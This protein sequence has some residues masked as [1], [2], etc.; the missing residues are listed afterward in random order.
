VNTRGRWAG[1]IGDAG[2]AAAFLAA[3]AVAAIAIAGS[4]GGLYWAF[5]CA[6]G[7]IVSVIA[8]LRRRDRVGAAIAGLAV[9]ALAI[10]VATLAHLPAEPGAMVLALSVLV[11]SAIRTLPP[12]PSGAIAAAGLAVAAG[13]RL[14]ALPSGHSYG[15]SS[16]ATVLNGAG[17]VAAVTVGLALRLIDARRSATIESVRR[18]ERLELARELHDVAAHHITGIVL[19]SQAARIVARRHPEQ[20]DA[21]LTDIE[22]AGSDALAAMRR[23]VGLLRDTEDAAPAAAGPEDLRELVRR[24]E[25]QDSDGQ[26]RTVRLLLPDDSGAPWPPEVT[27]TVYRVVQESLTNIAQHAQQASAV[28]VSVTRDSQAV[29]VEVVDDA[30]AAPATFHHRDGY[31]LIGMRERVEALGGTVTAGPGRSGGWS[32]LATLPA[33]T[34]PAGTGE[35]P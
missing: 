24:F 21:S 4:W 35:R 5:D 12:V 14:A 31:G 13:T 25:E 7:A 19:Q 1:A 26:R 29:T 28:T 2:L 3:I 8:L 23:V 11:G 22:S 17:W 32:V 10:P 34:L 15:H 16:G 20:L 6:T 33:G 9:A 27:S 18:D 30:P